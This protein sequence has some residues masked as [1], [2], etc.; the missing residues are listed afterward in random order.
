[1]NLSND[2][3]ILESTDD[4]DYDALQVVSIYAEIIFVDIIPIPK[5]T[6]FFLD[7]CGATIVN[8]LKFGHG[9]F[10]Q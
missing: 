3:R 6:G 4:E 8:P 1:M 5:G 7:V 9:R 2:L 10:K